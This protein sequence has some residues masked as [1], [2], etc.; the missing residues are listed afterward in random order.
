MGCGCKK[1]KKSFKKRVKDRSVTK[2]DFKPNKPI[3]KKEND[4]IICDK[5]IKIVDFLSPREKY[6]MFKNAQDLSEDEV[7]AKKYIIKKTQEKAK[8]KYL[9]K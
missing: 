5:K 2:K 1:R 4:R 7:V 8:C 3:E 6:I 9:R